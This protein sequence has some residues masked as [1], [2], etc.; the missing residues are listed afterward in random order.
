[1]GGS[2]LSGGTGG[3]RISRQRKSAQINGWRICAAAVRLPLAASMAIVGLFAMFHGYAHGA[4]MPETASGLNYGIGF[5]IATAG[6]HLAGIAL[7]LS[8]KKFA[9]ANSIRF[10]GGAIAACGIYLCLA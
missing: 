6:L 2:W 4:E 10:A 7:G 1:M 5:I 8:A 3:R 9:S